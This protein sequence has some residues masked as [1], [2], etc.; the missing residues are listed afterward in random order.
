VP[1]VELRDDVRRAIIDHARAEAPNECCGLLIGRG[2]LIDESVR[3]RNLD[4]RPATRYEVD[5]AVHVAAI[6]RLRGTD[7]AV[8]GCYHSHP[9][10]PPVPSASDVAEAWY[11]DFIWIIVSLQMAEPEVAGYRIGENRYERLSLKG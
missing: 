7:R 1:A 11:P 6:G 4:E 2:D 5:P 10:S 3:S 8:I 9:S